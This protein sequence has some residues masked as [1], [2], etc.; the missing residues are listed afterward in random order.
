M[1]DQLI[2]RMMEE[3]YLQR[4]PPQVTPP[5]DKMPRGSAGTGAR[6]AE[7]AL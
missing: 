4:Q 5:P 7:H 2:E 1:I 3:G 6:R